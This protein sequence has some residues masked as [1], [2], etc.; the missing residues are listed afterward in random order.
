MPARCN[1]QVLCAFS[2]V[3]TESLSDTQQ[4]LFLI[5]Y[6][7][8]TKTPKVTNSTIKCRDHLKRN[9][10][11]RTCLHYIITKYPVLRP[12]GSTRPNPH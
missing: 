1:A 7:V 3:Q 5:F 11:G 8:S 2:S 12:D 9:S 6:T 4:W 10:G